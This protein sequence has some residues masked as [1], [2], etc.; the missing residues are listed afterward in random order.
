[1]TICASSRDNYDYKAP[2]A[3]DYGNYYQYD[4]IEPESL[5]EFLDLQERE[6][7]NQET[8]EHGGD[9]VFFVRMSRIKVKA[10]VLRSIP[11]L[12][13]CILPMLHSQCS[14][15]RCNM[16]VTLLLRKESVS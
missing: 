9:L 5:D 4:Q 6:A 7:S 14:T 13:V 1:M 8:L 2:V 15:V 16:L 12:I 10:C 3:N 11:F